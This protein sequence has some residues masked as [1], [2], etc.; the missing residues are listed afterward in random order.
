MKPVS[1]NLNIHKQIEL[2]GNQDTSNFVG[3]YDIEKIR[4]NGL[5]AQDVETV[6]DQT[7]AKF[8]G[9]DKPGMGDNLYHL[10]YGDLI[11][12]MIQAMKE[13]QALIEQMNARIKQLELQLSL[14]N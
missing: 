9:L 10:R 2:L 8:T 11:V 14:K 3:K 4:Y 6:M 13:Q 1:Y 12:P 5:L 7:G